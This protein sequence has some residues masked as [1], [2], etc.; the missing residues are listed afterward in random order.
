MKQKHLNL[1]LVALIAACA[2][3]AASCGFHPTDVADRP[4]KLFFFEFDE[5]GTNVLL[6]FSVLLLAGYWYSRIKFQRNN[7]NLT[8]DQLYLYNFGQIDLLDI[9][10]NL[11]CTEKELELACGNVIIG[12]LWVRISTVMIFW[13]WFMGYD[14][15]LYWLLVVVTCLALRYGTEYLGI[16]ML[17]VRK[18]W[19]VV[20]SIICVLYFIL[21]LCYNFFCTFAA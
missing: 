8:Y 3:V 6:G 10:N 14:G 5:G 19:I 2:V 16:N 17:G 9:I 4:D 11:N 21:I 18:I 20:F 13:S 7:P 1:L 12:H 15:F